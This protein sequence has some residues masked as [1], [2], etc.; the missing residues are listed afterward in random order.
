MTDVIELEYKNQ[1]RGAF[2]CVIAYSQKR[3]FKDG[4]ASIKNEITT[5]IN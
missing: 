1:S 5:Q 4:G 2:S 3:K